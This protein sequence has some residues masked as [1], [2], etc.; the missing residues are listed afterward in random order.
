MESIR[1]NEKISYF[2]SV[3]K[4]LSSDVFIIHGDSRAFIYDVG[5]CDEATTALNE[6]NIPKTVILSHFHSDHTA[7]LEDT[8]FDGLY[9]GNQTYKSIRQGTVVDSPVTIEDGVIITIFPIPAVHAKGSLGLM[10]DEEILLLGDAT[11]AMWKDGH[12][13]YNAQL[14]K[15]EIEVLN[16]LPAQKAI[17]S[18]DGGHIRPKKA[19]IR[20]LEKIYTLRTKDS[21]YIYYDER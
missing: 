13:I 11:Y 5:N 7:H 9:V 6:M 14:L 4:P 18:H 8:V 1:L 21:P 20:L 17:L 2:P 10:I 16:A 15:D 3:E 12:V 19:V